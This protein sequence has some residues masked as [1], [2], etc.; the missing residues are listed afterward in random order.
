MPALWKWILKNGQKHMNELQ[1]IIIGVSGA[2]GMPVLKQCLSIIRS[3]GR[4]RIALVMTDS[5][6]LTYSQEMNDSYDELRSYADRICDINEMGSVYA[7]G[8]GN[9]AGM[10]VIPCSMKTLAG[11]DEGYTENLL[12]RAADVTVKEK[13]KLVLAVRESPLSPIHLKHMQSLSLLPDVWIM[14][15]MME[16]YTR[17]QTL[18]EMI[19]QTAARI[20]RPFGI[21]ADRFEPWQGIR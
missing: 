15:L 16:F 10:I 13:R 4:Y 2:S 12:L 20:V 3:D 19:Y 6:K 11:I 14:P 17:P 21:Q 9:A 1:N 5:A 18:E 7:S 8:S